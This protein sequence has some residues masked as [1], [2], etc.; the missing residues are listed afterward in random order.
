M[1]YAITLSGV[2]ASGILLGS[3]FFGGLLW[4]TRMGMASDNPAFWFLGSFLCRTGMLLAG[5]YLVAAS[6]WRRGLACLLGLLVARSAVLRFSRNLP[7]KLLNVQSIGD[8][9]DTP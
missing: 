2:F 8:R 9:R 6:D 1:T 3:L 7:G 5:I 4:S